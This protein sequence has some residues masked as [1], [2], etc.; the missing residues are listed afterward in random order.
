MRQRLVKHAKGQVN[1]DLS[2]EAAFDAKVRIKSLYE[3]QV[4]VLRWMIRDKDAS[5]RLLRH[6]L[7]R[8]NG[9]TT[10][11][12]AIRQLKRELA[13]RSLLPAEEPPIH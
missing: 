3:A 5:I 2:A 9:A 7:E 13:A 11:D 12:S 10:I 6:K 8:A 1:G 4:F